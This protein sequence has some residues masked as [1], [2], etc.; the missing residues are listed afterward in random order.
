ML[1]SRS[2]PLRG[3]RVDAVSGWLAG[4]PGA[5]A[6]PY[7]FAL[8]DGGRTNL[9]YRVTGRDGQSVALRRPVNDVP[10]GAPHT[11]PVPGQREFDL[12]VALSA[13]GYA[14]PRPLGIC[15]D[16]SVTGAPFTVVEWVEGI[17]ARDEGHAR[18]LSLQAR[19]EAGLSFI[20][21]LAELH[22]TSLHRVGGV[23]GPVRTTSYVSRQIRVWRNRTIQALQGSRIPVSR[24]ERLATR[25]GR[26]ADALGDEPA[27]PPPDR[28][29]HGDFRLDNVILSESGHVLAV[30]DWELAAVGNPLADLA[31]AT[32]MWDP[33]DSLGRTPP[34][35]APGF[36]SSRDLLSRY[37]ASVDYEVAQDAL[38][39]HTAFA[40]WRSA[41]IGVAVLA[42]YERGEVA[43][44]SIDAD[45]AEAYVTH[46]VSV[47]QH[48]YET[49]RA[50]LASRG[51][52]AKRL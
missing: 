46:Y 26:L 19:A 35:A 48:S 52:H 47:C 36:P 40:A 29:L 45:R 32:L 16:L 20:D 33:F 14:I 31:Y 15:V 17:V 13:I 6:R 24:A 11:A 49:Y 12:S 8:V 51:F 25:I 10:D 4:V 43:G 21:A 27:D 39:F 3:I 37:R 28:Q 44:A 38:K 50:G 1:L 7:E 30:V 2:A 22:R 23:P 34:T 5:P 41:C 18:R 9:T 42:R